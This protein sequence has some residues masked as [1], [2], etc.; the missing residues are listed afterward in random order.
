MTVTTTEPR[1][2][3]P[4][5]SLVGRQRDGVQAFCGVPYALPPVL[6][7]RWQP[8][9]PVVASDAIIDA[10]LFG[11]M[12]PQLS[13]T[14]LAL[15]ETSEDCLNLNIWTPDQARGAP[16]MVWLHGGGF[17]SGSNRVRG[18]VFAKEGVVLVAPNYRLGMLGFVAHP[19]VE[20][21]TAN[22]GL[23]DLILAL[24][25]VKDHIEAFG[26]DPEN[27]TIFGVSA[28][29]QAVNL[30]MTMPQGAGLFHKAIAQSGYGTWPLLRVNPKDQDPRDILHQSPE[31]A[32]ENANEI[33]RRI[34]ALELSKASLLQLPAN[35]IIRGQ[36]GFQR[37]IVDGRTVL[38]E[39]GR[40][41]ARGIGVSIP[42]LTGANSFDGSVMPSYQITPEGYARVWDQWDP[43]WRALYE[44]ELDAGT[45]T[46]IQR[47]FGD[48]RYLLSAW[49]LSEAVAS[50]GA[51][52]YRYYLDVPG[53]EGLPLMGS[54]HGF[55]SFL[56]FE[57]M[58]FSPASAWESWGNQLRR[59]WIE[60]ARVG[61][62]CALGED[63]GPWLPVGQSSSP[64]H[65]LGSASGISA[66]ALDARLS[67]LLSRYHYRCNEVGRAAVAPS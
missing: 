54:P 64:W 25:W 38:D 49:V 30:L 32:E 33:L 22:F 1:V 11:P 40:C 59:A 43:G 60:F 10:R 21:Q 8:P 65:R 41:L 61:E 12:A 37:P 63:Q 58:V 55:D 17:C 20:S 31:T 5:G 66:Q 15:A 44:V 45:E 28:G 57:S 39:P 26:G 14:G 3:L 48:E 62:P 53:P 16:V 36:S 47:L 4:Q 13:E 2:R 35:T 6:A 24:Q 50:H 19:L 67:S 46:G 7:R 34:A 23:L 56:L 29:G 9:S 52:A 18:S 42:Y 27:V 51:P